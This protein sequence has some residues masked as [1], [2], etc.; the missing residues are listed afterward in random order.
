MSG[1]D[2]AM[3]MTGFFD[4]AYPTKLFEILGASIVPSP[5]KSINDSLVPVFPYG[6][7]ALVI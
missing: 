5:S 1:N 6:L 4:G 2:A 7:G 3:D